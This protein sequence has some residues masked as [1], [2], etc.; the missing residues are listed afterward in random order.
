MN[1]ACRYCKGSAVALLFCML[2]LVAIALPLT[3]QTFFGTIV[4][5]I[6]DPSGA[7]VPGAAV[8]LTN[9][10]TGETKTAK[11]DA[12]G[13]Y[14]FVN[15]VP[16]T[17]QVAIEATGFKRVAVDQIH[18]RV[19][20]VSRANAALELGGVSETVQVS[21]ETALLQ[22]DT[23]AVGQV[24]ESR[25]IQE[26][27]LNGRNIMNLLTMVPSVIPQ[28]AS[29][30]TPMSN[31]SKGNNTSMGG[32]GNYQI[33]GGMAN[34]SLS[35]VDG[36]PIN[37][38]SRNDT[39]LIP[40]QDA[41]QEFNVATNNVSAEFGGFAG[42]V[43]NMTTKSGTNAFHGSAYEYLRND[44]FNA[45]DFMNNKNGVVRPPWKQNQWGANLGG[46]IIKNKTFFYFVYEGF[47]LRKG[48]ALTETVPTLLMRAGDFSEITQ[49]IHDPLTTC[50]QLGN[51]ACTSGT[52][53]T[54]FAGNKIPENWINP[55]SKAML[56]YYPLPN[57]SGV[58]NNLA[59]NKLTGGDT[60]QYM[61]RVDHNLTSNQRVFGRYTYWNMNAAPGD[62]FA[63]QSGAKT[64]VTANLIKV[65]Q[66]V[67]GDT[68]TISPTTVAD[69]RIAYLRVNGSSMNQN[70]GADLSQFGTAWANL[71]KQ[72]MFTMYPRPAITGGYRTAPQ[73]ASLDRDNDFSY[74][75]SLTKILGRHTVKFGGQLRRDAI[76]SSSLGTGGG[77]LFTFDATLTSLNA[78][79]SSTSGYG[80]ASFML[81]YPTSGS[82]STTWTTHQKL[83]S[84]GFYVADTFQ[85]TSKLTLNYG[86][87]WDQPGSFTEEDDSNSVWLGNLVPSLA[88]QTGLSL[89][90]KPVLVNSSDYPDRQERKLSW[91]QY[92]PRFGFA[93]RVTDK[94]VIR[95]AY[96]IS[97]LGAGLYGGG[98]SSSP[99]NGASTAMAAT[100]NSGLTPNNTF[101]NPFPA[102][103]IQPAG[104][105]AGFLD[106]LSG[107]SVS[108]PSPV[109][110]SAYV[111]QWNLNVQ[112]ELGRTMMFQI[113]YAASK[114][115][116]LPGSVTINQL[117]EQYYSQ[118]SSLMTMVTNP[119]YGILPSSVGVLGQK[120]VASGYLLKPYP[121]YL[122]V[123]TRQNRFG[124]SYN[125]LQSTFQK[126]FA[127]GASLTVSYTWSKFLSN[128]D[129][130]SALESA[131]PGEVGTGSAQNWN[132]L[133]AEKA[134]VSQDV[135]HRFVANYVYD[136][137][138]G[139]GKRYLGGASG[140]LSG[141]VSGWSINGRT[142]LQ[143]GFP[144]PIASLSNR[145]QST[146]NAGTIRP[147]VVPGCNPIIEGRAQ[148]RIGQWFNTA[149][150]TRPSD[151]AFGNQ[152]RT[153]P[154]VRTHGTNNWDLS[155]QKKTPLT[156]NVTLAFHAEFFNMLNRVQF[157]A[158]GYQLGNANFGVVTY[159]R[160][161]PRLVQFALRL[162]F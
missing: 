27:P 72:V 95:S 88:Q 58:T 160:N 141:V 36:A 42:G 70:V 32:W 144:M 80:F 127:E 145:L 128:T 51:P 151:Y 92:S 150:Y 19:D 132:N 97:F 133:N 153:D 53:R 118:G 79:N 143:S 110:P 25:T 157:N 61:A 34:K 8:T 130:G 104:R 81:G 48:M 102:G 28:G 18:V 31:Q 107:Q 47:A 23:V 66:L 21:A 1:Y 148:D 134:L 129:V 158:P 4:G 131:M 74:V 108:S 93:Y 13:N 96:G 59:Y 121:Q 126:R 99:V 86:L 136:L 125:A 109:Q 142:T 14:Q 26:M 119:F 35:Y 52:T 155:F 10:G 91:K 89:H 39:A 65:Q 38:A 138:V 68:I 140:F 105:A 60:S 115:T 44:I 16:G 45:N 123:S 15:L 114:G 46:P 54:V 7:V 159:T 17:Y 22:T 152:P 87:R 83:M 3:A 5:N 82:W 137:P 40:T 20:T 161:E 76:A 156:E 9:S 41:I 117:P 69:F 100:L 111:Q 67:L 154:K 71:A 124:S 73:S 112:R 103:L 149:C 64:G 43:V 29:E 147:N 49:K 116:H 139:K 55:T 50:G 33:G 78:T 30:G 106:S 135:P 113:G 77:G 11:S 98:P 85:V 101:S 122:N 94:L 6:T 84:Y 75:G 57:R 37:L 24:I 120:T 146:F 12:N 90:G 2:S 56:I 62:A 63:G 162:T